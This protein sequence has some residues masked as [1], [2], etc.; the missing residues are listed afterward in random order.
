MPERLATI[1]ESPSP[2]TVRDENQPENLIVYNLGQTKSTNSSGESMVHVD[3][4]SPSHSSSASSSSLPVT[5]TPNI[6]ASNVK[7]T[8]TKKP[9]PLSNHVQIMKMIP[10]STSSLS[11]F[12]SPV[13]A[14]NTT[15]RCRDDMF[16]R[17]THH[18]VLLFSLR[19]DPSEEISTIPYSI[20]STGTSS[21]SSTSDEKLRSHT[22]FHLE[23]N[24]TLLPERRVHSLRTISSSSNILYPIELLTPP[25]SDHVIKTPSSSKEVCSGIDLLR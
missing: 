10:S 23:T 6:P 19:L 13:G 22:D 14:S 2:Q 17:S 11:D 24:S 3:E 5:P 12:I 15:Q 25:E 18:S 9:T 7:E 4:T 1:Y 16:L 8:S 20:S 21:S